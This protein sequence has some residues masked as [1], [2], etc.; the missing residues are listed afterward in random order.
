MR[1]KCALKHNKPD[2]LSVG[3]ESE[4]HIGT[5][6]DPSK[7]GANVL[8]KVLTQKCADFLAKLEPG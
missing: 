7:T 5:C 6:P 8:S 2:R 1:G 4:F 3:V